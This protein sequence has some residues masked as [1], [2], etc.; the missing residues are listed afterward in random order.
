MIVLPFSTGIKAKILQCF[1]GNNV[2]IR[3]WCW[4]IRYISYY[5]YIKLSSNNKSLET[6]GFDRYGQIH[7]CFFHIMWV[8]CFGWLS[9]NR[10]CSHYCSKGSHNP[11]FQALVLFVDLQIVLSSPTDRRILNIYLRM[12]KYVLLWP[13]KWILWSQMSSLVY[14]NLKT[15]SVYCI[16]LQFIHT[17]IMLLVIPDIPGYQWIYEL[18]E[19]LLRFQCIFLQL[20]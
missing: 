7:S 13:I 1:H 5:L 8:I 10:D 12:S 9:S 18:S 14:S 2:K 4:G 16:F 17:M 20:M 6:L 3:F 15:D 19:E 11:G